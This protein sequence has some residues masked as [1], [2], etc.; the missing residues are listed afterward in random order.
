MSEKDK[1]GLTQTSLIGLVGSLLMAIAN[2]LLPPDTSNEVRQ[3]VSYIVAICCPFIVLF[4]MHKYLK[5]DV[6]PD[7]IRAR[8]ML[9]EDLKFQESQ[10]KKK[11]L[12]K[13]ARETIEKKHA[14]TIGRLA[15]VNQDFVANKKTAR[16]GS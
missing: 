3:S 6:D 11:G 9:E 5:M 2:I 15:T 16:K 13:E 1:P 4:I 14:D 8:S 12:S 10:L 7:L